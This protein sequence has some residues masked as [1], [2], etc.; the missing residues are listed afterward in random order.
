MNKKR[1]IALVIIVF[2]ILMLLTFVFALHFDVISINRDNEYQESQPKDSDYDGYSDSVD[3]FIYDE[4]EWFDSDMD[5][6]G[7]NSDAFPNDS[8]ENLDS[9]G[10]GYGD[11]TD[12]YP[13]DP[14]K[15][16]ESHGDNYER[17][18]GTW[19]LVHD[20]DDHNLPNYF[21]FYE[22]KTGKGVYD[23]YDEDY[24]FWIEDDYFKIKDI[25]NDGEVWYTFEFYDDYTLLLIPWGDRTPGTYYKYQ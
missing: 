2:A 1:D 22:G 19:K 13:N 10:D 17:F 5:G 24:T 16:V 15:W 14:E 6:I 4:T 3:A 18:Y 9:D 21:Y 8:S 25:V 12:Y 7:D 23:T 20:I 11:N